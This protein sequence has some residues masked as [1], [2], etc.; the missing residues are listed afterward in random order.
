[1]D[2]NESYVWNEGG[3]GNRDGRRRRVQHAKDYVRHFYLGRPRVRSESAWTALRDILALCGQ[4]GWRPI[5]VMTPVVAEFYREIPGSLL[6][7]FF[8]DVEE[9]RREFPE[10]AFWHDAQ[11]ERIGDDPS[12]FWD[13]HHLNGRGQAIYTQ[14]FV[15]RLQREGYL[16]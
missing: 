4:K 2:G 1:M 13:I 14:M 3:L 12:L 10:L 7:G 5:L 11:P 15:E 9:L 16:P 8:A 6:E